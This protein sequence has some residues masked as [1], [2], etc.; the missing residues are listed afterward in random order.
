MKI[1]LCAVCYRWQLSFRTYKLT[2]SPH[3]KQNKIHISI[4]ANLVYEQCQFVSNSAVGYQTKPLF[5]NF[6]PI[7]TYMVRK[8]LVFKQITTATD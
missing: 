8:Y 3:P 2:K 5:D 1:R 4:V 7:L 6:F